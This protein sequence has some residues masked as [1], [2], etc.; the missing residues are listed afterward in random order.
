M[1]MN[2]NAG[3]NQRLRE[4]DSSSDIILCSLR[5][6]QNA[7]L[8]LPT[9]QLDNQNIFSKTY[10]YVYYA[11]YIRRCKLNF[12]WIFSFST[13]YIPKPFKIILNRLK[14]RFVEDE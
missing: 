9:Q 8:V 7:D 3:Q 14:T 13:L 2:E 12:E 4:A 11:V 6:S 10:N 5:G 1:N